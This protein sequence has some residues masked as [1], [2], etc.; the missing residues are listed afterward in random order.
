MPFDDSASKLTKL[1]DTIEGLD[2]EVQLSQERDTL[3]I[4]Q[5]RVSSL[6]DLVAQPLAPENRQFVIQGSCDRKR[7]VRMALRSL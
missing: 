2:L 4:A 5:I 6:D 3:A 7:S 1:I